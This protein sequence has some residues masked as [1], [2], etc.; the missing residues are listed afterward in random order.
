[1]ARSRASSCVALCLL[2]VCYDRER[3]R[4]APKNKESFFSLVVSAPFR[5]ASRCHGST[6]APAFSAAAA[7]VS[8]FIAR[9]PH[10]VRSHATNDTGNPNDIR[11]AVTAVPLYNARHPSVRTI[12]GR[13]SK[14][15]Q[16]ELKGIESERALTKP[17]GARRETPGSKVLKERR[18]P[19]RRRGRMGTGVNMNAPSRTRPSLR[20][21]PRGR[22]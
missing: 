19:R 6:A 10:T 11:S 7:I 12:C 14:A 20:R 4:G 21:T 17:R 13:R 3:S 8:L 22:S 9:I 15:C 1:M 2:E 18:S 5:L 16:T